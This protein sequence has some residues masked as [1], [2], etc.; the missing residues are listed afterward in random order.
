MKRPDLAFLP[1]VLTALGV[2]GLLVV[3]A[4]EAGAFRQAVIGWASSD[5]DTR[6]RLAAATLSE[7]LATGDMRRL[8]EFGDECEADGVRLKVISGPA[9]L[10]FDS[11]P[12]GSPQPES[13]F[14]TVTSGEFRVRLY[15]P[16]ARVLAPFNRAR[17]G[18]LLAGLIGGAGVLLVFFV[19]Y[20]QKVRISELRRLETFRHEFVADVSHEIKTPLTGILGAVDM[21]DGDTP[22]VSL[23]RKEAKR[24][25]QLVQA[26]LDLAR[27]ER[28]GVR[29]S[30]APTD[31]AALSREEAERFGV[32]ASAVGEVVVEC[33]AQLVAQALDNLIVNAKRHSGSDNI[34]VSVVAAGGMAV[35]AVED[36]G[37]GVPSEHAERI[38]ER[39]HRVDAARSAENGGAGLGLA[40][41]RQIARLHGG[42]AA[43]EPAKPVGSRFTI[44]LPLTNR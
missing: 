39:F 8:R 7:A 16:L 38:F 24:L 1:A 25:N 4:L 10:F 33:D 34:E 37:R 18:F 32:R 2:I 23:V 36:R 41:V 22:L 12:V 9:G 17:I 11:K 15:L 35:I 19:T 3:F 30:L 26:I 29:L 14:A 40:I 43:Y 21:I 31:L 5:L 28:E 27:L 44:S 20:R 13:I 6:T 42:E